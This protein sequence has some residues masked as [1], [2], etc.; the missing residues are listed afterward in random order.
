MILIFFIFGCSSF[1][2]KIKLIDSSA[3]LA[4]FE[5][6]EEEWRKIFP[7]EIS[8]L[9]INSKNLAELPRVLKSI[10]YKRGVLA[11]EEWD[12]LIPESYLPEIQK[13]AEKIVTN[14]E[15]KVYLCIFKL[16]DIL[17][18]N[19]KILKTSFYILG[20]EDGLVLL[21]HEIN[22]NIS[23]Q[24][25]YSFEDWVIFHPSLIKPIY[26]PELWLRDKQ[27]MSLYKDKFAVKNAI[28]GNVVVYQIPELI[29]NPPLYRYPKEEEII[30]P[31]E[32]WKSVPEKL[33][34]LEEMRKNKLITD[35]EYNSKK[36]ELLKE[37]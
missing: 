29:P 24:T 6:E 21:F 11:Y 15:P 8:K 12:V 36:T 30:A 23:F 2:S 37:F 32:Q 9:N 16:D 5:V 4:F 13:F 17:S 35:E 31:V 3:S 14:K 22:T 33:K 34:A 25:Q 7:T 18:P 20:T 27:Q 19:V 1:S 10:Q 28:Y 26:R